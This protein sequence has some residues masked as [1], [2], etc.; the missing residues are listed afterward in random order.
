MTQHAKPTMSPSNGTIT[1]MHNTLMESSKH[2]TDMHRQ[3]ESHQSQGGTGL[4]SQAQFLKALS[5]TSYS[6]QPLDN[7]TQKTQT[8]LW[9]DS[10]SPER[11]I[12]SREALVVPIQAGRISSMMKG[13]SSTPCATHCYVHSWM[14]STQ[15]SKPANGKNGHVSKCSNRPISLAS[16]MQIEVARYVAL[17]MALRKRTLQMQLINDHQ[18]HG[19]DLDEH[20]PT[21]HGNVSETNSG[22]LIMATKPRSSPRAKL[23]DVQHHYFLKHVFKGEISI[24][25]IH[26]EDQCTDPLTKQLNQVRKTS[27]GDSRMVG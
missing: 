24:S 13:K 4:N 26:T 16:K 15:E 3:S 10:M 11:H 12:D 17:S 22:A 1:Q 6:V 20:K 25:Q 14:L 19:F 7:F 5:F 18:K 9:V 8:V 2:L 27:Q 21:V 23:F